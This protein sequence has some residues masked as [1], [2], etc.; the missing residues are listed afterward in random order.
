MKRSNP[1]FAHVSKDREHRFEVGHLYAVSVVNGP[2]IHEH[3]I[4]LSAEPG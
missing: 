1:Q 3:G 4:G 2:A